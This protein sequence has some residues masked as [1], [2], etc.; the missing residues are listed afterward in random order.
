MPAARTEVIMKAL[1]VLRILLL[2]IAPH[3]ATAWGDDG[4]KAIALIA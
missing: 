4:H 1:R 2:S 3:R